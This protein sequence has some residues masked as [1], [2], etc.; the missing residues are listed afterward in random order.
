MADASK[1]ERVAARPKAAA[2]PI[3]DVILQN[4]GD[5]DF[6]SFT[7]PVLL[8]WRLRTVTNVSAYLD[9]STW[10]PGKPDTVFGVDEWIT[11]W[12]E[13]GQPAPLRR[14]SEADSK[15][16]GR[17]FED[18]GEKWMFDPEEFAERLAK[19]ASP[20]GAASISRPSVAARVD[21]VGTGAKPG[22][23]RRES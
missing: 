12:N 18:G 5:P 19:L 4:D 1:A 22:R 17:F 7:G 3:D 8:L 10:P 15:T 11:F 6:K 2:D 13:L 9:C 16:I 14:L 21:A 20:E 23:P